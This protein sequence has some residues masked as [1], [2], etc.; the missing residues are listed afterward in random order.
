[1]RVAFVRYVSI[2]ALLL[3]C[4]SISTAQLTCDRA[5]QLH[6]YALRVRNVLRLAFRSRR[7]HV[8]HSSGKLR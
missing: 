5:K 4:G 1:M 7:A 3:L 2:F 8:V 6:E